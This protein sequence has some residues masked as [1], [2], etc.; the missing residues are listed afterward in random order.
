MRFRVSTKSILE[1]NN[2]FLIVMI[3]ERFFEY[4]TPKLNVLL[5]F[6]QANFVRYILHN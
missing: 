4:Y 1:D 2:I 3:L 6:Q 5:Q